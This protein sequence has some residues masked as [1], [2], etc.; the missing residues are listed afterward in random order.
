MIADYNANFTMDIK[1]NQDN[2]DA[3][4]VH[5]HAATYELSQ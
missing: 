2:L 1:T 5:L 3:A 4:Q